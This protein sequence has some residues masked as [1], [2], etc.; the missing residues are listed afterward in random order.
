MCPALKGVPGNQKADEWAK[1]AAEEPD[2]PGAEW[3]QSGARS[4]QLPRSLAHL[5][6]EIS[7]KKW[8]EAPNG[9]R[10]NLQEEVQD[11]GQ[12]EAGRNGRW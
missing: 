6:R 10:L 7:E 12:A 2:A 11:G 3:L 1:L 9:L 8:A 4:T 5:K